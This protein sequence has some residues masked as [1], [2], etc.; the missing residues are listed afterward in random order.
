MTEENCEYKDGYRTRL[1]KC[2]ICSSTAEEIT[3][4]TTDNIV[5]VQWELNKINTKKQVNIR[6]GKCLY[7]DN[8]ECTINGLNKPLQ[9][10]L[11]LA[12]EMFKR[13]ENN[14]I[15]ID[16]DL[17]TVEKALYQGNRIIAEAHQR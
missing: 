16:G 15:V 14:S 11:E 13:G 4:D 3:K 10:T 6:V 7:N 2:K 12:Q 9:E 17:Y 8:F 5:K 1:L